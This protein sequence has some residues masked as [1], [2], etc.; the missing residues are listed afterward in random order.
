MTIVLGSE[1]LGSVRICWYDECVKFS[2]KGPDVVYGGANVIL[3][4]QAI[5][6]ILDMATGRWGCPQVTWEKM[7]GSENV[8]GIQGWEIDEKF[9]FG[10]GD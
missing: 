3:R 4:A 6:T 5:L 7:G 1:V 2:N 8:D 10:S 9:S